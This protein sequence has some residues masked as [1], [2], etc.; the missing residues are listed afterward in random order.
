MVWFETGWSGP[1]SAA[2]F[3]RHSRASEKSAIRGENW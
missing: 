3:V 2:V 1:K